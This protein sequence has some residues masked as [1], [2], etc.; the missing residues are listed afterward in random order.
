MKYISA[1]T[2]RDE[3][4][5]LETINV[6]KQEFGD[7]DFETPV[8]AFDHSTY[9]EKE[10]GLQLS[11]KILSFQPLDQIDLLVT[12]KLFTSKLEKEFAVDG[13]RRVNIDPAYLELA[14]LVVAT[15]KNYDH[16]IHLGDG[17]Y[18]DVQLRYRG[19]KFVANDWTYPD[20]RSAI[21]MQFL[22]KVRDIYFNQLRLLDDGHYL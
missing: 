13:K 8:F 1:I 9:Y 3:P 19:R 10:M 5:L 11:K 22:E 15:T 14:K 16:R 20:Y 21:F 4:L 7:T 6:L 17:I 12:R 18:G 2:F